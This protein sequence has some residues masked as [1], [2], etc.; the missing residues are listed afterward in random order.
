MVAVKT[1]KAGLVQRLLQ[2]GKAADHRIGRQMH[3]RGEHD[4]ADDARRAFVR[5]GRRSSSPAIPAMPAGSR[6]GQTRSDRLPNSGRGGLGSTSAMN[7]SSRLCRCCRSAGAV[8]QACLR[9][10]AGPTAM[11]PIRSAI[12]SATSRICVV[13]I[14]VQPARTRSRSSPLT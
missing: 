13:M 11:T 5:A 9:R 1:I 6:A 2:V 10:S 12:R 7:M 3:E 14:T 4:Q 8:R